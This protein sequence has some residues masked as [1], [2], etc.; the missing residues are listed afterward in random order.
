MTCEE[1]KALSILFEEHLTE[2]TVTETN[3]TLVSNRTG[4]T[5]SLEAFTDS[6]SSV[7][8]LCAALLD[9]DSAAYSVSPLSILEADRLDAFNE[10]VYIETLC[11]TYLSTLFDRVDAVF[12][13]N[14]KDLLFTSFI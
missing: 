2:V 7:S 5:E 8:S 11:L 10:L 6:S 12:L 14:S 1:S 4:D 9:S 3:L 13:D